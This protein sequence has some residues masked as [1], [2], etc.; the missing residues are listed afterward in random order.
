MHK[1]DLPK[2]LEAESLHACLTQHHWTSQVCKQHGW[3]QTCKQICNTTAACRI[4]RMQVVAWKGQDKVRAPGLAGC[5]GSEGCTR[6]GAPQ[7][8]L[9]LGCASYHHI[10]A[11]RLPQLCHMQPSLKIATSTP[12]Q[13]IHHHQ[14]SNCNQQTCNAMWTT[15]WMRGTCRGQ[16]REQPGS[17]DERGDISGGTRVKCL[18]IPVLTCHPIVLCGWHVAQGC[19]LQ[20]ATEVLV[21]NKCIS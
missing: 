16:S 19:S 13:S 9:P 2:K 4:R 17:L 1:W 5:K 12:H 3:S 10:R 20:P 8:E 15:A 18:Y 7:H 11:W 6:V 21:R 14:N